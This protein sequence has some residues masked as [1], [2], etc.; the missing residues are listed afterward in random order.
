MIAHPKRLK[1]AAGIVGALT[2]LAAVLAV[3]HSADR[4]LQL[5][6]ASFR[7]DVQQVARLLDG[8]VDINS[9]DTVGWTPLLWATAGKRGAVPNPGKT[10]VGVIH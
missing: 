10:G 8:G 9:Q 6:R 2:L 7:G 5:R 3:Q 1:V 4:P